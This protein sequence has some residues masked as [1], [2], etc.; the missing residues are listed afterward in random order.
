MNFAGSSQPVGTKVPCVF[1]IRP[2]ILW[3]MHWRSRLEFELS[4]GRSGRI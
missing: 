3:R 1:Y 4:A 2:A